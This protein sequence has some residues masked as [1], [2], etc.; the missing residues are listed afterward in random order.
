MFSFFI[1][2]RKERNLE[3]DLLWFEKYIIVYVEKCSRCKSRVLYSSRR[4]GTIGL[5][6]RDRDRGEIKAA[7]SMGMF[8][9]R[10]IQIF[11]VHVF[12]ALSVAIPPPSPVDTNMHPVAV[13]TRDR[14]RSIFAPPF[15]FL[16]LI[17]LKGDTDVDD[18]FKLTLNLTRWNRDIR[19]DIST[20]ETRRRKKLIEL[21]CSIYF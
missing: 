5:P 17:I 18:A 4:V 16:Q 9:E 13:S 21:T 15:I 8:H 1:L 19:S 10:Q 6:F 14:L 12:C 20:W 3:L 7:T 2:K 11:T